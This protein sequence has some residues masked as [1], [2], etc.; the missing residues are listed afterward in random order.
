MDTHAFASLAHVRILLVPVGLTP[1]SAFDKHTEDIR[2]FDTIRLGDI[3]ADTKDE[4]A[5]FMPN[6]LSAGHLHLNFLSHPPPHSHLPLSLLRPSHFPL[7]VIGVAACSETDS[8]ASILAQ[9]NASL[10]DMFPSGGIFPLAK[11]CFVFE[12]SDGNT[13]LNIGDNLPGLVVIPSMLGNK[14]LY[15]GTLL[16]DLCSNILGEFGVL[17]Q[18]LESPIGNEYLNSSMM[19]ILPPLSDIPSSLDDLARRDSLPPL[20]SHHSQPEVSRSLTLSAA[21]PKRTSSG[22]SARQSTLGVTPPKKRMSALGVVSSHGRLYKTFGDLFLL[23][24]RTEDALIWYTE[25]LLLFKSSQDFVWHAAVLEGMSTVSIIDAWSAGHGLHNSM[26]S[27]KEPWSDVSEKLSQAASLYYRTTTSDGEV[28]YS[29]LTYLYCSCVLRRSS[30]L[31]SVW[32]A[33][34]WGP[35]AFTALLHPGSTHTSLPRSPIQKRLSSISGVSR[36]SI[37]AALAQAHGP[38]LLHLGPRERIG[39]LETI[40]SYYA[41]IGY[42][43]KEAYILR[44][45]LGCILDLVV[46]GREEDGFPKPLDIPT[47]LGLGIQGVSTGDT[48]PRGAV[49]I[50]LS[51]S[52]AGNESIL[53]V[54]KYICRVLG[55]DLEAVGV[56]D[57]EDGSPTFSELL[58]SDAHDAPEAYPLHGWPE[59]QVGVVREAVAVAEALPDSIAVARFALSALKTLQSALAPGDQYHLYTTS[60]RALM[61]ARRRGDSTLVEY[62]SGR[63][64][65]SI[66]I[67]PLPFARLPI[68]KPVS[69][70]QRKDRDIVPILTGGTDPFL[71]N[72]RKAQTLQG[73]MLVIQNERLEFMV[74]LQN[75]YIFDLELEK[76]SLSTSGVE[77]ECEPIRVLI[78]AGSFHQVVIVGKPLGTGNLIIKGCVV[79][80]PGGSPR[81]FLLPL[82]SDEEE[83]R[84]GRNRSSWANEA[85]RTKYSGLNCFPWAKANRAKATRSSSSLPTSRPKFLQCDVIPEQPMLRIRRTSVTHGAVML[86]NGEKSTIRITIENIS[87]LPV[88]FLRVA[89]EDST[90]APAQLALAEGDL[91]VF[92]TYETEYQLLHTPVFSWKQTDEIIISPGQKSTVTVNCFG[93]VGCTNGIIHFSYAFAHRDDESSQVFHTRQLSY[94]V[95]VTVYHMLECHGMDILP[96]P[97]HPHGET[98]MRLQTKLRHDNL[99]IDD[100]AWCLFSVEVRNTYGLPFN[101]TFTRAQEGTEPMTTAVTVPPGSTSRVVVPVKKFLLS[102]E[103]T[104]QPIPTLSDRQYVVTKSKLSSVQE[105]IQRELFW[106]R[107]ELFKIIRGNWTE[108]GGTRLGELSLRQQRL[109]LSMLETLRLETARVHMSLDLCDQSA[110]VDVEHRGKCYP[111]PNHHQP[112][113]YVL[114]FNGWLSFEKSCAFFCRITSHIHTGITFDPPEHVIHEGVLSD[115]SVGRLGSGESRTLE[116]ALCFLANGRIELGAVVRARGSDPPVNIRAGAGCLTAIMRPDP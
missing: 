72:P 113:Q 106:Y 116:T 50:R 86:Y 6:P 76:L 5:R 103:H 81:E 67:T 61:T 96:S 92:E 24:G 49:G 17:V 13:N 16:A 84:R 97:T 23:A 107:E 18:S 62:W 35:L 63:P 9:F 26:S 110:H 99:D 41:C 68:E 48:S 69:M 43:R 10:V 51:E 40:A 85:I 29:L 44:E 25:A 52:V 75:P 19:P 70:L 64:V 100:D 73:K 3:P 108:A 11:N 38:W 45:V 82:S 65:V 60:N 39:I 33:K 93:K 55:I 31:F 22:P 74:V 20:P 46:C 53:A 28:Q 104:S 37:S 27:E 8:L 66:A 7:A 91:S 78:A 4:R 112:I 14:K 94:P 56:I 34:G 114:S 30:L 105:R 83:V 80:A 42:K 87:S 59:L 47:T 58:D 109:T 77:V 101:V 88:D 12:E 57:P 89:F 1:R 54:L 21:P 98:S 95:M 2:S 36:A 79:Q 115:L 32:S 90:I 15:I 102:E 111:K 71:Y